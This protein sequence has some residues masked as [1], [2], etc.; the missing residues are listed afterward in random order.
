MG[1]EAAA[2]DEEDAAAEL[3]ISSREG[4]SAT[5]ES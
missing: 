2:E 1:D 3:D 5:S 4:Y